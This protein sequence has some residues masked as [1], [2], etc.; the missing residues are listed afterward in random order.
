MSRFSSDRPVF[1]VF[2][3]HSIFYVVAH[4]QRYATRSPD[5]VTFNRAFIHTVASTLF[6]C[7]ADHA[8]WLG[9]IVS[10]RCLIK[11]PLLFT[12]PIPRSTRWA[13][14]EY[15]SGHSLLHFKAFAIIYLLFGLAICKVAI[16]DTHFYRNISFN[17]GRMRLYAHC[18]FE[19]GRQLYISSCTIRITSRKK[20]RFYVSS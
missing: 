10:F 18:Y 19:D 7:T 2:L 6:H 11:L 5:S 15:S 8:F 9:L 14:S 12:E 3:R 13:H 20:N 17:F 16:S 1:L 4:T